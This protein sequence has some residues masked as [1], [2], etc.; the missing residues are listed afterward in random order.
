MPNFDEFSQSDDFSNKDCLT[1]R[2]STTELY[3]AEDIRQ[4]AEIDES[5]HNK[6]QSSDKQN[7]LSTRHLRSNHIQVNSS[8]DI[9]VRGQQIQ[10]VEEIDDQSAYELSEAVSESSGHVT[11]E[12]FQDGYEDVEETSQEAN[13]KFKMINL[14]MLNKV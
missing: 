6:A 4:R 11:D 3:I 9:E 10:Q 14:N 1:P 5:E 8:N 12:D 13:I 7:T 2:C